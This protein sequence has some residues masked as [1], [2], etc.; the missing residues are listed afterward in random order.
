MLFWDDL[1]PSGF[2]SIAVAQRSSG[3]GTRNY[4]LLSSREVHL[5]DDTPLA[6]LQVFHQGLL[7]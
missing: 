7:S 1:V 2:R 5:V 3:T 4:K 6:S